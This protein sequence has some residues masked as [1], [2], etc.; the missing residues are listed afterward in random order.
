LIV[1]SN[2]RFS[3][4]GNTWQALLL[5]I[6]VIILLGVGFVLFFFYVYLPFTTNHGETI[7]VPD[8]EKFDLE[9][10]ADLL[11]DRDLRYTVT[12]SSYDPKLPPLT[13]I[14]QS[15]AAGAKV[16]VNRRIHL[17]LNSQ[18]PP[19]ETMPNII[20]NSRRQAELILDSYGFKLGKV[21]LVEDP[22][23]NTVL[24]VFYQG[25][26]VTKAQLAKGFPLPKGSVIDLQVGD[27]V[28]DTEFEMPNLVGKSVYEAQIFMRGVGLGLNVTAYEVSGRK[29]GTIIKQTPEYQPGSKIKLG[30]I[31]DVVVATEAAD[32][33][34]TE[35][36]EE[37]FE[38]L[39]PEPRPRPRSR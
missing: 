16:K 7:T 12:D 6:L 1:L 27:G 3:L 35:G 39:L 31:I 24:K 4:R 9:K 23:A 17:V 2:F 29:A 36:G 38:G 30:D 13:V 19:M 26:E 33:L 25:R 34:D 15:P 32:T 20:D 37:G 22:I 8:V 10:A 14:R 28:G 5:N 21:E 18:M 11:E